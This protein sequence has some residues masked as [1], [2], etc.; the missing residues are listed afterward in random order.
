[1][2]GGGVGFTK[3][4]EEDN[5]TTGGSGGGGG[6]GGSGGGG[7]GGGFW[8]KFMKGSGSGGF[9]HKVGGV[10]GMGLQAAAMGKDILEDSAA[11][12]AA[13]MRPRSELHSRPPRGHR[14]PRPARRR[15]L[16]G[17]EEEEPPPPPPPPP[18]HAPGGYS[19]NLERDAPPERAAPTEPPAPPLPPGGNQPIVAPPESYSW[20]D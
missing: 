10:V 13:H 6:S 17:G 16:G 18:P 19:A 11:N 12:T 8:S 2:I 3:G 7:G 15:R 9:G 20:R 14:P 1:M 4:L 5:A